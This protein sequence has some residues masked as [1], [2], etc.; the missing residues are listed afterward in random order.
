VAAAFTPKGSDRCQVVAQHSK[1]PD[2]KAAAKMKK[3]WGEALDRLKE[4]LE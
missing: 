1:L 3:F 4:M 2:S